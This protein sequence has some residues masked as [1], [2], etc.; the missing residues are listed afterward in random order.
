MKILILGAGPTGLGAASRLQALGHDGWELWERE[1]IPGGLSRSVV[2]AHGFTWD[3]GGHVQFSH[4]KT[5][6]E[7]MDRA[8]GAGGWLLHERESWIRIFSA[9]VPYPFQYNIHRLPPEEALRCL[10]G[11]LAR[12]E[13]GAAARF[14]NF[15]ELIQ[16][17]FG[18]GIAELFMIPY[19]RKV[20]GCPPEMLSTEWIG[21]RVA[22]PDTERIVESVVMKRDQLSWGPNNTFRFAKNGGTGA[23]WQA[24]A[25]GLPREKIH[26]GRE[27]A[28]I[29]PA[30][31]IVRDA[32]GLETPYDALINTLP[33][34][35]LTEM[36]DF[37]ELRQSAAALRHSGVHV[38]GVALSGQPSP[39]LAGKYWMYFPEPATPFFRVTVFSNYSP[40]N[41]PDPGRAWSL[42]AEVTETPEA[43]LDAGQVIEATVAGLLHEGLIASRQQVH[44]TWHTLAPYAYPTPALGRDAALKQ[45][46]PALEAM[47]IYSRG[48]FGAWRYEVSNQDHSMMQGIE[49]VNRILL[50]APELTLWFPE[51]VNSPHPAYGKNWL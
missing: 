7:A 5:F 10:K 37:G 33:V 24:I 41:V 23:V 4:Y 6:D 36:G 22:L 47:G 28:Q 16:E 50:G 2:D 21:E 3:L 27:A 1:A 34:D 39:E 19:N 13:R 30:R 20:W 15:G 31:K 25:A 49:A 26:Y 17:S 46:L 11:L 9:W 40:N 35:R 44:H 51:L 29:D 38:I 14:A 8:L 43:P 12:K 42:M 45:L 48:R 32:R 18:A